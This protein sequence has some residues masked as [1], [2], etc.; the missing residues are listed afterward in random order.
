MIQSEATLEKNLIKKLVDN[1]YEEVKI[2]NENELLINFR[3]QLEKFNKIDLNDDEFNKILLHLEGGTVFDKAKK[4]RDKYLIERENDIKYISFFNTKD[5]CKNVFQVTNQIIIK[6]KY[7]NRYDVTILINGIPLVQIELKR[8]GIELKK[9][10]NQIRRYR[11]HSFHGLFD[12]IQIFVISNGINT[13]YYSNNKDL[14]F[15][16]TFFW[17]DENNKNYSLL[18]DFADVFLEKCHVSKMIAR[19]IVF[20]ES[21]KSLMVL[22]AYQFYAVERL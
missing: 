11:S 8:R 14:S 17:K 15:D 4:L 22:R 21:S 5:W 9:A 20:N 6:G 12:Y 13:K 16:Y 2:N 10:F 18:D 1:G 7:E 19:Y 3:K